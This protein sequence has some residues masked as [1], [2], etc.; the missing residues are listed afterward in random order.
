MAIIY[1]APQDL[2]PWLVAHP[3]RRARL[4]R[5]KKFCHLVSDLPG[6]AGHQELQAFARGI[7]QKD[8][9][10]QHV[11][12]AHEHYD[13]FDGAI[14][15]AARAGARQVERT[16]MAAV[17]THKRLAMQAGKPREERPGCELVVNEQG[18]QVIA[19]RRGATTHG[20]TS[21]S[22]D[23]S[24]PTDDRQLFAVTVWA[25]WAFAIAWLGKDVENRLWKRGRLPRWLIG[26]QLAIHAGSASRWTPDV[27]ESVLD[28]YMAIHPTDWR[29][30]LG[31]AFARFLPESDEQ[32]TI[33]QTCQPEFKAR[34]SSRIVAVARVAEILPIEP[35]EPRMNG[36]HASN[37][38]GIR[39]VDVV[40]FPTGV[41]CGGTITPIFWPVAGELLEQVRA[42][43]RAAKAGSMPVKTESRTTA[44]V[45]GAEQL[46]M[47][48]T[49]ERREWE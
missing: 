15:R 13:L 24:K 23:N 2:E 44:K 32:V 5:F 21:P 20:E 7:G 48:A 4:G 22:A 38:E 40:P 27:W 12:T 39:L 25:P 1:D 49:R 30:R 28:V 17:W 36:W 33:R 19:C 16:E 34:V 45:G 18:H 47:F 42:E 14:G 11:G 35:G 9:W 31:A 46:S 3:E 6:E 41:F 37:Q 8:E 10:A 29:E 43:Y 26:R